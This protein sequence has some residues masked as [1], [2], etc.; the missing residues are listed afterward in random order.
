MILVTGAGGKTG[1]AVVRAL[2]AARA[3]V[4][5]FV[6]RADH[7]AALLACGAQEVAVGDMRS[8]ADWGRTAEGVRAVYH[9]CPNVHPDEVPIG[10]AAIA[11]ARAVGV[12]Q[13]VFHSVLHPQTEAMPHHWNKLRVEEAVL[14]SGLPFTIFQP[15]PY[16]QNVLAGLAGYHQPWHVHRAL[17]G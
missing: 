4:R 14:A 2:A 11:A 8:A 15:A 6:R 13:F 12:E 17:P 16:M 5:A 3:P 1:K 10:Q 9:I 7:E